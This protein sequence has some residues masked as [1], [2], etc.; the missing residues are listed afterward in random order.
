VDPSSFSV[1]VV[2]VVTMAVLASWVPASRAV[3]VDPMEAHR[4][5]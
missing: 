5:D 4:A 3:R 1:I 2:L